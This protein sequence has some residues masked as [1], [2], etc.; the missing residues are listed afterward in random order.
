MHKKL[1]IT[2]CLLLASWSGMQRL[3]AQGV[4]V[5][6]LVPKNGQLSAPISPFS[7]RNIRLP[8]TNS[9]G[10]Q[11]GGTLYIFPGLPMTD[12]PFESEESLRGSTFGIIAPLELYLGLGSNQFK[13]VFSGGVFGL[14]FL[15]N[16]INQGLWDQAYIDFKNWEV[17]NGNLELE[18]KAGWGW[19]GG[20]SVE[21]P[22]TRQYAVSI[23]TSYLLGHASN[24]LS[25]TFTGYSSAGGL[26]SEQ[27]DLKGAQTSLQGIEI[28]LGVSF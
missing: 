23:G 28:S 7:L 20:V 27:L 4:S 19:T 18:N 24:P 13:V 14:L 21:V 11:T 1:L 15:N 22:V 26:V 8:L 17:G 5:S 6:Y 3:Q 12:L 16:R 10:I 2:C 25:G 9:A